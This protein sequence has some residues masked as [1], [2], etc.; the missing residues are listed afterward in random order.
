MGKK[1]MS[2]P[3][4]K[5]NQNATSSTKDL[6][7]RVDDDGDD[8]DEVDIDDEDSDIIDSHRDV[9]K[10][11]IHADQVDS[12]N[13]E[14]LYL[15]QRFGGNERDRHTAIETSHD[16]RKKNKTTGLS[17]LL[18]PTVAASSSPATSLAKNRKRKSEADIESPSVKKGNQQPASPMASVSPSLKLARRRRL[19]QR[20]NE[21]L[22]SS[23]SVVSPVRQGVDSATTHDKPMKRT[24][25][26]LLASKRATQKTRNRDHKPLRDPLGSSFVPMSR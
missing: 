16:F 26:A 6:A 7:H 5:E 2:S 24:N 4:R 21:K 22:S 10:R 18:S 19:S 17:S 23:F 13:D 8:T 14:D 20:Q 15:S 11:Y 9:R 25:W 1:R 12:E 3:L